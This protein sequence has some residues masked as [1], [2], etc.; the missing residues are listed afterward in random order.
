[1]LY[2]W[3]LAYIFAERGQCARH[4]CHTLQF[5]IVH[6]ITF[7]VC[8]LQA[9]ALWFLSGASICFPNQFCYHTGFLQTFQAF[10]TKGLPHSIVTVFQFTRGNSEHLL[11]ETSAVDLCDGIWSHGTS[12]TRAGRRTLGHW[13]D[14]VRR[15]LTGWG[16]GCI[17]GHTQTIFWITKNRPQIRM[18]NFIT[19]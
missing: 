7:R 5:F 12:D 17:T 2:L 11:S 14:A 18:R 10:L 9:E 8:V 15:V 6:P 4:L 1:M 13:G 19:D 16:K 3:P